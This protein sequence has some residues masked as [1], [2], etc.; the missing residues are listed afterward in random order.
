MVIRN[1]KA[2][3]KHSPVSSCGPLLP[4]SVIGTFLGGLVEPKRPIMILASCLVRGGS[5]KKAEPSLDIMSNCREASRE[6][7]ERVILKSYAPR[8]L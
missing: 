6:R 5:P 1:E 2:I 4:G 7:Q 3:A 8:Y